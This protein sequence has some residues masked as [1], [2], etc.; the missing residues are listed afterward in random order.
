MNRELISSTS[1]ARIKEI[2]RLQQRKQRD[3]SGRFFAEGIRIVVEALQVGVEVE[4]LVV[5]PKLLT[6]QFARE[7]VVERVR[8]GMPCLEVTPEVFHSISQRER[9][10]GLGA[11]IRQRWETLHQIEPGRELCWVALDGVQD[12][13]NL[14]TMLRTAD[15]VGAAGLILL[16]ST[17]D[18]YDPTAVRASMGALF[19]MRLVRATLAEL[20]LWKEWYAALV[21]GTSGAAAHDYRRL[22]YRAPLVLLM[23]SERQGLSEEHLALCD[24]VVSIPMVGRVDSLNLAVA[25]GVVLYHLFSAAGG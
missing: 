23:G 11:V 5:A 22:R 7:L 12:P 13:G 3:R 10:Q 2:R 1:N 16:G 17:V 25:T 15:A 8:A 19:T 6:S 21:V 4:S 20:A 24:D 18:P 9:P 14:G